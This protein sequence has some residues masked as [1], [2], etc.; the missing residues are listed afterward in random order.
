VDRASGEEHVIPHQSTVGL[1]NRQTNFYSGGEGVVWERG[2]GVKQ[3]HGIGGGKKLF[4]G[5]GG[6]SSVIGGR[7]SVK[8]DI[9]VKSGRPECV[10]LGPVKGLIRE[11][12]GRL[13]GG[14]SE[15]GREEIHR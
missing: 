14:G 11:E 10:L 2:G 9:L 13:G 15:E 3:K 12:S 4:L 8:G 6:V 5:G 1:K 7:L